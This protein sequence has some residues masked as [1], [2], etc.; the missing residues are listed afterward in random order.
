MFKTSNLVFL[1]CCF[2]SSANDTATM[3]LSSCSVGYCTAAMC[4]ISVLICDSVDNLLEDAVLQ[5]PLG[6]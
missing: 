2:T 6:I 5:C 1:V 3:T 4:D